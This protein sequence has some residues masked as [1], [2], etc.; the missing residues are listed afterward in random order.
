MEFATCLV[1]NI[2]MYDRSRICG[3]TGGKDFF[4]AIAYTELI[5]G[6]VCDIKCYLN[7]VLNDRMRLLMGLAVKTR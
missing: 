2:V 1:L 6:L 4:T 5:N 3:F 7:T